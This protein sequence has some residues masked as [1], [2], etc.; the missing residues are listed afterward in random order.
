MV[1]IY[2][3]GVPFNYSGLGNTAYHAALGLYREGILTHILTPDFR[4]CEIPKEKFSTFPLRK[5][6]S[7]GHARIRNYTIKD[8]LFD[9]WASRKIQDFGKINVFYG[10]SHHSLI[11]MRIA[12]KKG[13]ITFIDRQSAE[14]R[15]QREIMG[16]EF[17][18]VGVSV[19]FISS[20]NIKKTVSEANE[21]DFVVV[22][23][24]FVRN[25]FID[26]G[27]PE[28]KILLNPLGVDLE[29]FVPKNDGF[30]D[31]IFRVIFMGILSVQ[32]GVHYLIRAWKKLDIP[33]AELLLVGGFDRLSREV[34]LNEAKNGKNV[35]FG[36]GTATPER[37][38]MR[39]NIFAFP[40]NQDGFGSVV[41]EAMACGLPVIV[42]Q[43]TGAK[44]CVRDGLEGFVIPTAD[45]DA[46]CDRI[47][48]FYKNRDKV[49]EMGRRA[50]EQALKYDWE[51]YRKRLAGSVAH[52][53]TCGLSEK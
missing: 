53:V 23:S 43:N 32:K 38:F 21:T 40:S 31:D 41:L 13:A 33:K 49:E 16:R 35:I 10:W 28:E 11:S 20:R 34:I 26:V 7:K 52:I 3:V 14:I 9:L 50:R 48:Y 36:G 1:V 30:E 18:K 5:I 19:D 12:H 4:E 27:Y 15:F 29:R 24:T 22:P 2:S 25:T 6:T 47:N 51:S 42:S 37:E 17:K 44:D 45:V 8:N 39:S 46:L